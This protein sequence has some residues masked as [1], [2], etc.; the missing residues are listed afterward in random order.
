MR[1]AMAVN[2]LK[3]FAHLPCLAV[4]AFGCATGITH[5]QTAS[6]LLQQHKCY[7]CHADRETKTGPAYSD[8]ASRYRGNAKAVAII[9]GVVREGARGHGPWHMPPHPE[10]SEADAKKMARYILSVKK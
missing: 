3:S 7:I 5:A 6:T 8:V 2:P 4:A 9:A 10:I 1:K